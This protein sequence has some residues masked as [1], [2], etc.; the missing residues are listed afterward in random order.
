MVEYQLSLFE[1]TKP[2]KK[3]DYQKRRPPHRR[4]PATILKTVNF[5]LPKTLLK[6]YWAVANDNHLSLSQQLRQDVRRSVVAH[7]VVKIKVMEG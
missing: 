6:E 5:R 4:G 3:R 1:L 7:K 2:K